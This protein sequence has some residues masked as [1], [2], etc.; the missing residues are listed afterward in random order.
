MIIAIDVG[1]T[2]IVIGCL[3]R[4]KVL[5]SERVS[6]DVSKTEL[7]YVVQFQALLH[8]HGVHKTDVTGAVIASVVPPLNNILTASIRKEFGCEPIVVGPGVKNGLK[9]AMD[10]P[11]SVGADL[12]VDAVAGMKEYGAPFV[13]IDMGTA[14]TI[15]VVNND[16]EYIGGMIIPGVRVS[17]DGLAGR[18]AQLPRISLD[19]PKKL[20]GTNTID[21]MKSGIIYG[22]A[23]L[24]DG[25]LD[26][27]FDEIGTEMPVVAT[28]GLAGCIVSQCRHKIVYD[29]ELTL[30][31]LGEVYYRNV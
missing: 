10:N 17:L 24:L 7:E 30:K 19:P 29:S 3:E 2:N 18:T 28:G 20:I 4:D 23:S 11:A 22:Q 31:G 1:N 14:T 13:I 9:I 5:F 26:R 15:S 25:M 27:I 8:L 21:C 12:I 6:T 16:K